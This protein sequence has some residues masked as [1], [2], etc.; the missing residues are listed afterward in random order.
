MRVWRLTLT[1]MKKILSA[2]YATRFAIDPIAGIHQLT[3]TLSKR[4]NH[5]FDP[6][7]IKRLRDKVV[8]QNLVELD[9]AQIEQRLAVTR[10]NYRVVRDE[11]FKTL[12][13]TPDNAVPGMPKP[14]AR[15]RIE[16]GKTIVMLD[17]ALLQAELAN[18]MYKKPVEI[19]AREIHYEPLAPEVRAVIIASW[20][21]GGLLPA[22]AIETMVPAAETTQ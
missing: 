5:S 12:Y 18:G 3:D 2:R 15:D 10:E 14:Q 9:R 13:W 21:R 7:Y 8:R 20:K 6:R 16:A 19:I 4:L 17:L 22:A 1:A 11:L